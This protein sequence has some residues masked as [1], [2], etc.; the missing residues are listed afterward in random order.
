M[1]RLLTALALSAATAAFAQD[2]GT[3]RAPE[4]ASVGDKLKGAAREATG[5]IQKTERQIRGIEEPTPG[6]PATLPTDAQGSYRLTQAF[7]LSGTVK[8]PGATSFTVLR[9][10]MPPAELHVREA[11]RVLLD[12]R[13]VKATQ[14]PEGAQVRAKFQLEGDQAVALRIEATAPGSSGAVPKR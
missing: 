2:G 4:D 14:L 3:P 5:A 8:S 1:K 12:G 7:D 6:K 13:E 11:T 9:E 10:G